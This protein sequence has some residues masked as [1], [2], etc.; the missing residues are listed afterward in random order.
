MFLMQ[1]VCFFKNI[2]SKYIC[3][4]AKKDHAINQTYFYMK[5][6]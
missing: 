4:F 2:Y 1:G 3:Q 5:I 6:V